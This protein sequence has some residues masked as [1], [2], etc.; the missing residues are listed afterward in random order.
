MGEEVTANVRWSSAVPELVRLHTARTLKA[1]F[2]REKV[3]PLDPSTLRRLV[4][5][6][7]A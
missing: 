3:F 6:R 1:L 4:R 7:K 2:S 5:A